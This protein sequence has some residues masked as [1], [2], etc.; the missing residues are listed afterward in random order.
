[1]NVKPVFTA[2]SVLGLVAVVALPRAIMLASETP[3]PASLIQVRVTIP[4][5]PS[6]T[7][8]SDAGVRFVSAMADAFRGWGFRGDIARLDDL[9]DAAANA[10]VLRVDLLEWE[11]DHAGN[12]VCRFAAALEVNGNERN[13]GAFHGLS[14]GLAAAPGDLGA[15]RA[16]DDA[17][18]DA[19]AR[20]YDDLAKSELIV[21]LRPR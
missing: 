19:L 13:L 21:G 20:L 4:P 9:E 16:F 18:R 2:A 17:A 14:P 12:F 15:A 5:T 7:A 3:A 11:R 1:M 6:P 8:E 10:I